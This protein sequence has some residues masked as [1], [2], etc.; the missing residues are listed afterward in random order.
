MAQR[1]HVAERGGAAPAG[2]ALPIALFLAAKL[3][4]YTALGGLLGLFGAAVG[5]SPVARGWLQLAT[6]LFMLGVAAQLLDLHPAFRY[7][8]LQPP[9]WLQRR[10]RRASQRDAL[11]APAVL[12]A[13]TVVIPCRATQ[14]MMVAAVGSGSPTRGALIMFA[15]VLGTSPLFFALGYLATRLGE[16]LR[17]AFTRVAAVVVAVLAALSLWSGATLVGVP[18]GVA[19]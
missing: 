15:F 1:A 19:A 18:P 17:G 7:F 3:A 16:G 13:M 14:A 6:G 9:R 4:A 12:G 11:F 10:I 5:L 2:L 8:S